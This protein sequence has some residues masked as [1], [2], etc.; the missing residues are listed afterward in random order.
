MQINELI[1]SQPKG[2]VLRLQVTDEYVTLSMIRGNDQIS[3]K[4]LRSDVAANE[5]MVAAHISH[6][7][8]HF[9]SAIIP[10]QPSNPPSDPAPAP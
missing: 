6:M 8:R 1:E 4:L 2:C 9:Q 3:T 10:C 5:Y 7:S